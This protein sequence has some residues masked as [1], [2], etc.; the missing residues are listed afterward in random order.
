MKIVQ[1][2]RVQKKKQA[3]RCQADPAI[4]ISEE[5]QPGRDGQEGSGSKS[6]SCKQ[7]SK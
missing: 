3:Q 1:T 7:M 2:I 5:E 6:Q 4:Q